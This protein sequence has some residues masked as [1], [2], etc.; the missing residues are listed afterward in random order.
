MV[1]DC[2]MKNVFFTMSSSYIFMMIGWFQTNFTA[3]T[4]ATFD[5]GGDDDDDD[6]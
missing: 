5:S 3:N 4:G 1:V 2:E 6:G